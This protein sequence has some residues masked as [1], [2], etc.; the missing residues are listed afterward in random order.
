MHHCWKSFFFVPAERLFS[1]DCTLKDHSCLAVAYFILSFVAFGPKMCCLHLALEVNVPPAHTHYF[2]PHK[3]VDR[4]SNSWQ[5]LMLSCSF[6]LYVTIS[7]T[8]RRPLFCFVLFF[9]SK[10]MQGS[11]PF[12]FWLF[13]CYFS[14]I[15]EVW[16]WW[17]CVWS[18][19]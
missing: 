19:I 14:F 5:H 15:T 17:V 2:N 1:G 4:P 6:S 12:T 10:N 13:S 11:C 18:N 16:L 9:V 7:S 8:W 3:A